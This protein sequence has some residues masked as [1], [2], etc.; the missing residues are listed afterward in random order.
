MNRLVPVAD[1]PGSSVLILACLGPARVTPTVTALLQP[2]RAH[3]GRKAG[4]HNA[5]YSES[6]PW[7]KVTIML[8]FKARVTPPGSREAD[9][10]FPHWEQLDRHRPSAHTGKPASLCEYLIFIPNGWPV[11]WD[12]WLHLLEP[13]SPHL[14]QGGNSAPPRGGR[15]GVSHGQQLINGSCS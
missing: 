8:T 11:R 2:C 14:R 5:D 15:N 1:D 6:W 10:D 9:S 7:G 13:L 12:E 3:L 4:H